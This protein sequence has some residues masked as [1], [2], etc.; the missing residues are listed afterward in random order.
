MSAVI[1]KCERYRY[2]LRREW[3][4]RLPPFVAGMLNPSIADAYV[5]DPTIVR[6]M[7]RARNNGC[8]SIIVWN[9][10]AGRATR[11]KEWMAMNDPIGPENDRYILNL[12]IECRSRHGVAFVGWGAHGSFMERNRIALGIGSQAGV[13]FQ[14]LGTTKQGH[15]RHPLYVAERRPLL[16]FI[17]VS[18]AHENLES[19]E[20]LTSS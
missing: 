6:L 9:L 15:P 20:S 10:G 17:S 5:D 19:F 13:E 4:D 8:G 11:P 3:D 7:K 12:L 1:S 18:H 2:E 16:R 14:C